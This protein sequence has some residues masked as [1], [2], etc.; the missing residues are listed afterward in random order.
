MKKFLILFCLIICISLFAQEK[1]ERNTVID[2]VKIS[3]SSEKAFSK[4]REV[5][6]T[7]TSRLSRKE[8]KIKFNVTVS[9]LGNDKI[10]NKID[11]ELQISSSFIIQK[12]ILFNSSN[13]EK[14][15]SEEDLRKALQQYIK[16]IYS[17]WNIA[18]R[19]YIANDFYC[20][21]L[22]N[23][24]WKFAAITKTK[25]KYK[26]S[27]ESSFNEIVTLNEKGQI[28]SISTRGVFNDLE[29]KINDK[30]NSDTS[31]FSFDDKILLSESIFLVYNRLK[32]QKI[33][34][35]FIFNTSQNK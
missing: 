16:V 7:S 28:I 19:K 8:Q 14:Q 11:G 15:P 3:Q 9:D 2:T 29:M 18:F 23:N 21:D 24:K 4:Y 33:A 6:N 31:F 32:E 10:I 12:S 20:Y 22:G 30:E 13:E 25:D 35:H 17:T 26:I 5:L 34:I 27:D 1:N